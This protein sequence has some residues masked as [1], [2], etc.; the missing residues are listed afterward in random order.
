MIKSLECTMPSFKFQP[1]H[2]FMNSLKLTA[3][4]KLILRYNFDIGTELHHEI[5]Y[6]MR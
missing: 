2:I 6:N 5:G 3:T 4:P 1:L